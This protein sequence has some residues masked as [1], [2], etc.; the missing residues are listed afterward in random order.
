MLLTVDVGEDEQTVK[1]FV[2]K[3]NLSFPVLLDSDNRV[4]SQ[5]GVRAHP[6]AYL[7]D[8]EGNIIGIAQGYREWYREEMKALITSLI[9]GQETRL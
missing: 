3:N 1:R 4:A 9:S 5:Y 8:S 7:I 6:V 2:E